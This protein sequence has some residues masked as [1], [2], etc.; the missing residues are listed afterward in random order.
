MKHRPSTHLAFAAIALLTALAPARAADA[1]PRLELRLRA[2]ARQATPRNYPSISDPVFSPDGGAYIMYAVRGAGRIIQRRT[3]DLKL[4]FAY[5]AEI[6]YLNWV[7]W[8]EDG[9]IFASGYGTKIWTPGFERLVG[10]WEEGTRFSPQGAYNRAGEVFAQFV[11]GSSMN[12]RVIPGWI[13]L[14]GPRADLINKRT[15]FDQESA[16]GDLSGEHVGFD[17][18]LAPGGRHAVVA[19]KG[20]RRVVGMP[21]DFDRLVAYTVPG[22]EPVAI[23]EFKPKEPHP[24]GGDFVF[25]ADG[26][27]F[28]LRMIDPDG[29]AVYAV[30]GLQ[31]LASVSCGKDCVPRGFSPDGRLLAVSNDHHFEKKP[32]EL[33]I[34][35]GE[36]GWAVVASTAV[37]GCGSARF[38]PDGRRLVTSGGDR[39]WDE[40]TG[41]RDD[42]IIVWDLREAVPSGAAS[43]DAA[44]LSGKVPLLR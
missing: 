21:Q 20:K 19:Y 39:L 23:R 32:D 30:P 1:A 40:K 4:V 10:G 41:A 13:E 42:M 38:S 33:K 35:D 3:E 9:R 8:M 14:R 31:R 25:T 29:I 28:A 5:D 37:I 27:R 24:G 36:R 16:E 6:R 44:P 22:L 15:R 18:G 2:S 11:S 7:D 43:P 34:L 26:K 17:G 12:R